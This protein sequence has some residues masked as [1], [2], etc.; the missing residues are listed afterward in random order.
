MKKI[1]FILLLF[2][3]FY[4]LA[5]TNQKID[6]AYYLIDTAKNPSNARVWDIDIEYPA[7]KVYTI[8]CHCLQFDKDI[9]F[10]YDTNRVKGQVISKNDFKAINLINLNTLILK[11][12]QFTS[13]G[14]KG[15]YAIFIVEPNDDGYISYRVQ[16][17]TPRE[18]SDDNE[19]VKP[20]DSARL[21][22]P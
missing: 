14:F 8:K 17:I 7:F 4:S 3:S 21:K 16:L 13:T 20:L 19:N 18:S 10:A 15:K 22:K 2:S 11:A 1:P 6:S 9:I 12:K 5:Q